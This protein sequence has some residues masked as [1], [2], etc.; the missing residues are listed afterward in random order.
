MIYIFHYYHTKIYYVN[1]YF[2]NSLLFLY[3]IHIRIQS[4]QIIEILNM[5]IKSWI[6]LIIKRRINDRLNK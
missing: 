6:D 3:F 4:Q 2:F 5:Y 1:F